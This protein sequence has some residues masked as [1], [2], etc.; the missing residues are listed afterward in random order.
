MLFLFIVR[1]NSEGGFLRHEGTQQFYDE[2]FS[3]LS[4]LQAWTHPWRH[5]PN[6]QVRSYQLKQEY[7]TSMHFIRNQPD[8]SGLMQLLSSVNWPSQ[9]TLGYNL[10]E[11]WPDYKLSANW[12]IIFEQ[13]NTFIL[14]TCLN[15]TSN[16]WAIIEK[17]KDVKVIV[18]AG[19]E[20][21]RAAFRPWWVRL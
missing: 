20:S 21:S 6:D 9:L 10:F 8:W 7:M 14:F 11:L 17:A 15:K 16:G 13:P 12:M 2:S 4:D 18:R 1:P 19:A 5:L 3:V